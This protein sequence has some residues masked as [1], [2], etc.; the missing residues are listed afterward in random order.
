MDLITPELGLIFWTGISFLILLFILRK[1]AWKPI[2]GA[3]NTREQSI[4][5]AL[6]AAEA[7][8]LEMQNL[9]ADNER[10]L[11]EARQEREAMMKEARELKTKMITDAKDEAKE[12]TDKMIAQAQAAIESEKKSAMAE[13]K[14]QVAELSLEIAEKVVKAELSNKDKQ[15]QL[16]ENMLDDAKLN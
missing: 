1:F 14:N 5:D 16:V 9:K 4:K 12:T 10:I 15:L 3:V 7:A 8:K 11:Q 6:A 2:L 13:L